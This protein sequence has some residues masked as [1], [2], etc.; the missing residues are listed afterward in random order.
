MNFGEHL[1]LD[2]YGGDYELLNDREYVRSCFDELLAHLEMHPLIEP[3]II[4]APDNQIK[5][6]GGWS[7]YVVIAESHISIHTFPKRKFISADVYTCRNGM[8][9]E[10][11][12]EYFRTKFKLTDLET[13]FIV[14]GT[15]YPE[16]NLV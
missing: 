2:G 16:H 5:D 1:T 11:I 6:P 14:R 13:N 9:R 8:D 10:Y 4:E 12:T 7:G 3:V 15:R